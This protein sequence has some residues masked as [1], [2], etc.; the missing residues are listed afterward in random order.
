RA[1]P[2]CISPPHTPSL[3]TCEAS[4]T[5]PLPAAC[6]RANGAAFGHEPCVLGRCRLGGR[7]GRSRDEN[8]QTQIDQY[9]RRATSRFMSSDFDTSVIEAEQ[10]SRHKGGCG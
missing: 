6:H 1:P 9:S 3:F 8:V 5:L 2:C 7:S 4:Y 10:L